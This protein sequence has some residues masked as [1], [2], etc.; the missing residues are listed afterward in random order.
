MEQAAANTSDAKPAA[1]AEACRWDA[2]VAAEYRS[3]AEGMVVVS[4]VERAQVAGLPAVPVRALESDAALPERMARGE[5]SVLAG[6][7]RRRILAPGREVVPV[8]QPRM[9]PRWPGAIP[10]WCG[11]P[12]EWCWQVR[13]PEH[14][15]WSP[16]GN[17]GAARN[18]Q[19]RRWERSCCGLE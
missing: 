12:P 18:R 19:S 11:P 6:M 15:S 7:V 14:A 8:T 5:L 13:G 4:S 16:R 9:V 1:E 10:G 17:R 2:R 3:D